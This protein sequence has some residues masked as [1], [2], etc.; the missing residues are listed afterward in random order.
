[1]VDGRGGRDMKVPIRLA[2]EGWPKALQRGNLRNLFVHDPAA[3]ADPDASWEAFTRAMFHLHV[4]GTAK[5]TWPNRQADADRLLMEHVDTDGARIVEMGASDGT[6]AV[7]LIGRLGDRFASYTITD[8]WIHV[9]VTRHAGAWWVWR[10][11]RCILV[12]NGRV[13][14]W[15]GQSTAL[16]R[17]LGP[18]MSA[19]AR[20]PHRDVV[21]LNPNTRAVLDSDPRVTWLEHDVFT[22]LPEPVDVIKV[23]N[24]L[25]RV[26]FTDDQ[27]RTALQAVH[28]S[29]VDGGHLLIADHLTEAAAGLYRKTP[30]G[31]EPIAETA[32]SEIHELV[33]S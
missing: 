17:L 15:P 29:L 26:Y 5:I 4:G 32:R 7:E 2:V 8:R 19:A 30:A 22:P 23:G 12:S 24:L 9:T 10:D 20:R 28:S 21:M 33:A 31:F 1:M 6:T 14:T 11:E 18:L 27:I 3:I 13:V 16:A 25:R